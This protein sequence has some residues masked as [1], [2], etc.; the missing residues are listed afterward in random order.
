[1][2]LD[3]PVPTE[4]VLTTQAYV[5][6]FIQDKN[7]R[8]SEGRSVDAGILNAFNKFELR[9]EDREKF[10]HIIDEICDEESR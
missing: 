2:N 6:L 3:L 9:R 10:G 8:L 7:S 5:N 1:M 4:R